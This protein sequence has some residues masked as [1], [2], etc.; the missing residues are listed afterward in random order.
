MTFR[1]LTWLRRR[2]TAIRNRWRWQARLD[3]ETIIAIQPG[4]DSCRMPMADL[5]AVVIETNDTG[6]FGDDCWWQLH[7]HASSV[8]DCVFPQ[9]AIG[10]EAVVQ[11]LAALPGFDHMAMLMAMGSTENVRFPVWTRPLAE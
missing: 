4:G 11:A 10:S 6:P 7:R 5:Q 1:I 9:S 8:P 3:G 2:A